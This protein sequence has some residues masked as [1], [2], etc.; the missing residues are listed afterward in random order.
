M[1]PS[2]ISWAGRCFAG[3][4]GA[5]GAFDEP[6]F[7]DIGQTYLSRKS[8]GRIRLPF[9]SPRHKAEAV[10]AFGAER[11]ARAE[12]ALGNSAAGV[13]LFAAGRSLLLRNSGL[14]RVMA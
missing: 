4:C 8:C 2:L 11:V 6:F 10:L 12:G 1:R 13:A 5:V 3:S 9:L 14:Q 7:V